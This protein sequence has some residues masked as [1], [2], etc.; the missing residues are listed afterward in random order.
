MMRGLAQLAH[1]FFFALGPEQAH[2]AAVAALAF[3]PLFSPQ[4][5]SDPRLAVAAFGLNFGNP[6][7]MAAGFDKDAEVAAGLFALGFGF[8]EVGTLT[9]LAQDGNPQPRLFRLVRDHALVNRL[10]FNNRGFEAAHRRLALHRPRGI[11]GVNIGPNKD[12]ADRIADFVRGIAAFADLASYFT[13]NVSSPNTPGLRDLQKKD[14]LDELVARLLEARE[15]CVTRRPLLIKIAPDLD[16]AGLDD[17]VAV[18]RAR[19]VDGMIVSNTTTARPPGLL[20]P[21]ASEAGGLSGRPLFGPSTRLLAETFV[22]VEG[23]FPLIGCGGVDSAA[24]AYA[25]VRAGASLVQLYTGLVYR[26]PLV[27]EEVLSGLPALLDADRLGRLGE[28]VGVDARALAA[29]EALT[30]SAA[31]RSGA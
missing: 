2:R 11:L 20:E 1:P 18:A 23:A 13:I 17:I 10:G 28:A 27:V 25:K 6:I 3:A 9:P 24:A 14:A 30:A 29:G 4:A 5:A 8:V 12:S 26:G 15:L 21:A 16:L 7:G 19:R 22:R 31:G